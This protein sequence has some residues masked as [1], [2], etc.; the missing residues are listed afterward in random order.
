MKGEREMALFG[1]GKKSIME[2]L[3]QQ[4][5]AQGGVIMVF[6]AIALFRVRNTRYSSSGREQ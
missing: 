5:A 3:A 1:S 6:K 2:D 4:L